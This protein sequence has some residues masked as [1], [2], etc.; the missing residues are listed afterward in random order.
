MLL[1]A[2]GTVFCLFTIENSSTGTGMLLKRVLVLI[3]YLL[4]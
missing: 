2:V 3:S 1:R 4:S